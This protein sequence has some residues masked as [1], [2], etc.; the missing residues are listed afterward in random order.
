MAKRSIVS[1]LYRLARDLNDVAAADKSDWPAT[2]R[3]GP[4]IGSSIQGGGI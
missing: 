3:V 2:A 1:A 4:V